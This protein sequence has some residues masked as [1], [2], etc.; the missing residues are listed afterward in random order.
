MKTKFKGIFTLLL[1][2][3]VQFMFAQ[4]NVSGTVSDESGPLAG[5]NVLIKG[6]TTGTETNFDGKYSITAKQGDVLVFSYVG[7]ED[8]EKVIGSSNVYDVMLT[9]GTVLDEVVITA[10]GI[11]RE[12]KSLGYATQQVSGDDIDKGKESSFISSLSGKVSG[13]QIKKPGQMGGSANIVVRGY[14]SIFGSNQALFVVDG[15]PISNSTLNSSSTLTNRGGYDYGNAASDIDPESIESISILKGAAAT[16][17]YG[18]EAANGVVLIT[19][20]KGKTGQGLGVTINQSFT[21]GDYDK[22]TFPVYQTSYGAGYGGISQGFDE[23]DFDGDGTPDLLV[24]YYDDASFG[25]PLDGTM[26]FQWN[27]LYPGLDTYMQKTPYLPAQNSVDYLLKRSLSL[28]SNVAISGGNENGSLRLGYTYDDRTGILPNS[29]IDT[30]IIDLSGAYKFNDNFNVDAKITYTDRGGKGRF[31]T[32]Y[33][34]GNLM[35]SFRQWYQVNVDLKEQEEAYLSTL[36]N[37]TWN[38]TSATNTKPKYFDNPYWV[39]HEN[40]QTD[41]RNRVF[42]KAQAQYKFSNHFNLVARFGADSYSDLQEERKA[43]GSLDL[44]YY[45]KYLRTFEQYTTDLI[46]NYN[47]DFSDHIDVHGLIGAGS[48]NTRINSTS[49]ST[50]GGLILPGIYSLD[51]SASLLQAPPEYDP[52]IMKYGAYAQASFSFYKRFFLEGSIRV[53]QSSTLPI[54]DNTYAYPSGS[55]SYIFS[56]DLEADWLNL[57]KIRASYAEVANDTDPYRVYNTFSA[58]TVFD[59]APMYYINNVSNNP[60]LKPEKTTE[61]EFG[62]EL[63]LFAKRIGLDF[64]Y[65]DRETIDLITPVQVSSSTG[66]TRAWANAG[67]ISNKGVE[68]ALNTVPVKTDDFTWNLNLNWAKNNNEVVSLYGDSKN[69]LIYSAW[70]AA[71]NATIGQPFGSITGYDF[72]YDNEGNKVIGSDGKYLKDLSNSSKVIGNIQP[73][74]LGGVYNSFKYKDFNLG[75]LIDIQQGGDIYNVDMAFGNATGLYAETA[76][77]NSQGNP[78]RDPVDEG[79]GVLLDGVT[80]DVTFGEDSYTV[81]NTAPNDIWAYAGNYAQ[82]F[83]FYGGSID[84]GDNKA[85][86][87]LFVYDASYVKLRELS[88]GYTFPKRLIKNTSLRGASIGMYGRNLWIIHKNLPYGDPEYSASAGNYQGL[89]NGALPSVKEYGFNVKLQF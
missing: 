80:G 19:T 56:E 3:S 39:L 24:A 86:D 40:F 58:G 33:D 4:K 78:I 22:S 44:A 67:V 13:V 54:E 25:P 73:D 83:G 27:A 62:L 41:E 20:K 23:S 7:Y 84:N 46:L 74:W 59:T 38:A 18:S 30:H 14:A 10:L 37:A 47:F 9:G 68:L 6:T 31:G 52:E 50:N 21:F 48:K 63:G 70:N 64:S 82:P 51:N 8:A 53:D 71:M 43:V 89:Q 5:V 16:A 72:V 42:A 34:G 77:L 79:G 66:F 11:K 65:Y 76:G 29:Q 15:I 55:L 35:Q 49:L 60:L 61:L 26:V 12:K 81:E 45:K 88:M 75:F 85:P 36:T 1:A 32:G 17:L 57:G 2:L 69:M 87:A 28:V